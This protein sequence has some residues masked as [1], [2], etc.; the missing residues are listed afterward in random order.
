MGSWQR[1]HLGK[2]AKGVY[3]AVVHEVYKL[4]VWFLVE[5]SGANEWVLK[6]DINLKAVVAHFS[7]KGHDPMSKSWTS[8]DATSDGDNNETTLVDENCE[9]DSDNDNIQD[10]VDCDEKMD[11]RYSV[12]SIFGFH[13]F[14]E[15]IFLR[16]WYDW[17]V[18][19]HLNTLKIQELGQFELWSRRISWYNY[20]WCLRVHTVLD[21]GVV[22]GNGL[23]MYDVSRRIVQ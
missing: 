19:Y 3:F 18:A 1:H 21:K 7:R 12:C 23:N 2:S 14:R 10:I 16:L 11:F 22:C 8:Q 4:K 13:P 20:S 5:S 6:H 9:W 15:V 17:I